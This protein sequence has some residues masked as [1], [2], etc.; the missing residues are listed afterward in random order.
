ME[1]WFL[2]QLQSWLLLWLGRTLMLLN[3]FCRTKRDFLCR[4]DL[5]SLK[6]LS[7]F[8]LKLIPRISIQVVFYCDLIWECLAGKKSHTKRNKCHSGVF[9]FFL[10]GNRFNCIQRTLVYC[11]VS[12][13]AL[14]KAMYP[15]LQQVILHTPRLGDPLIFL[16]AWLL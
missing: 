14:G 1:H 3:Q 6:V 13:F 15:V 8:C 10:N 16:I 2:W 7:K 9:F 11:K 5:L 4:A 12:S